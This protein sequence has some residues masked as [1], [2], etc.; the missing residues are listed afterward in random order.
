MGNTRPSRMRDRQVVVEASGGDVCKS[1]LLCGAAGAWHGIVMTVA[2]ACE[3]VVEWDGVTMNQGHGKAHH[4]DEK[5]KGSRRHE[6][7]RIH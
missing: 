6:K 7:V 3:G 5:K 1:L 2:C 4:L